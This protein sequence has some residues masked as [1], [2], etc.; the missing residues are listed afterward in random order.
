M[1]NV[2]VAFADIPPFEV[3]GL[4]DQPALLLGTD[5]MEN[6]RKVSLDFKARKVRFQLRSCGRIGIMIATVRTT[7]RIAAEKDNKLVCN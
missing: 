7:S 6:F 5:M 2:P 3:F 4:R 1:N